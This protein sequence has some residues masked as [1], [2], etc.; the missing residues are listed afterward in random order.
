MIV[1]GLVETAGLALARI[2][3]IGRGDI[4]ATCP[5]C[6]EYPSRMR[7]LHWA[8][9][10]ISKADEQHLTLSV[11]PKRMKEGE[12]AALTT[13]FFCT[14]TPAELNRDL[15]AQLRGFVAGHLALSNNLADV[16]RERDEA[17]KAAR[18][19]LKKKQ[20]TVGNGGSKAKPA[21]AQSKP[22]K[23]LSPAPPPPSIMNLFDSG[24]ES[25]AEGATSRA[26]CNGSAPMAA[27]VEETNN[28]TTTTTVGSQSS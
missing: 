28:K 3:L 8:A 27:N 25:E 22:E 10:V 21:D 17:E 16:Q 23:K 15:P 13:P 6:H 2:W 9:M 19:E 7:C 26:V 11:V 4:C 20:K 12:N 14:G 18:E 24:N 5:V 1:D